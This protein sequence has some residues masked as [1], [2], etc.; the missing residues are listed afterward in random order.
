[1]EVNYTVALDYTFYVNSPIKTWAKW[2]EILNFLLHIYWNSHF[3]S[4]PVSWA[5]ELGLQVER[6]LR[7]GK[8]WKD[9]KVLQSSKKTQKQQKWF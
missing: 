2:T 8:K 4:A 9:L 6:A 5:S 7:G 3:V 1:M